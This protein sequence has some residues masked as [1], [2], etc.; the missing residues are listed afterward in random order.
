MEKKHGISIGLGL[1][2]LA[3]GVFAVIMLAK[4]PYFTQAKQSETSTF[5][6]VS[7]EVRQNPPSSAIQVAKMEGA[8]Q[9]VQVEVKSNAY[10]PVVVQKGV[11][12]KLN[13]HVEQSQLNSCNGSLSLPLFD[14]EVVL[15]TGDNF[16]EF[17][18]DTTG[19]FPYACWMGMVSSQIYVVDDL[20]T[21]D[22]A[23]LAEI[24]VTST[25]TSCC[26]PNQSQD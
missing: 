20:E 5:K 8:F 2:L 15:K 3:L 13:F 11:P 25:G 12:V 4:T 10:E 19:A 21:A 24:P 6:N 26:Q 22:L 16:L 14:Q 18:P 7:G 9:S 17:T 1:G 23:A